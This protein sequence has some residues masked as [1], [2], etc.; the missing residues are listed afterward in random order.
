LLLAFDQRYNLHLS[1]Q[2]Q[3]SVRPGDPW[4]PASIP[5]EIPELDA[6]MMRERPVEWPGWLAPRLL[7]EF[8]AINGKKVNLCDFGSAGEGG[9]LY[10]SWLPVANAPQPVDFSPHNPLRSTH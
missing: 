7:L 6:K 10:A 2:T 3:R 1:S 5:L 4:K 9:S 8:A